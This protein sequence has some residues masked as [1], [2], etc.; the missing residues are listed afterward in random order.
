MKRLLIMLLLLSSSFAVPTF[1]Y[2]RLNLER[3]WVIENGEGSTVDFTGSLV[4][5]NSNQR[6]ISISVAHPA[7]YSVDEDGEVK[8]KYKG[9]VNSSSFEIKASA[10]VNVDYDTAITTDVPLP[11]ANLS[12]TNLTA[13]DEGIGTEA[14]L[15]AEQDSSLKTMRNTVNWINEN[16]EYDLAYWGQSSP[17]TQVFAERKG[18]CVEYS[19]LLISMLRSAGIE[20]RYVSGYVHTSSWQPHAWVEAYLPG[21]G[22]V[23]LDPTFSQAGILDSSHIAMSYGSD[24]SDPFDL[25]LSADQDISIQASNSVTEEFSGE[26][27]KGV[28]LS[29][30]YDNKTYVIDVFTENT[31]S[32]YVLG[33]YEFKVPDGYGSSSSS[34]VLLSPKEQVHKYYGLNH[35]LFNDGYS[36]NVPA[37]ASFNDAK[38][39]A[40]IA[41]TGDYDEGNG[42]KTAESCPIA[43]LL[44]SLLFARVL[45]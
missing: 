20:T 13:P 18:V 41:I 21:Y 35:S 5:N 12:F 16:L 33:S 43:F 9:Q 7:E 1:G 44:L 36:Y 4:V 10:L 25:L 22:W 39:K 26:D 6:V 8:V 23:S 30:D 24:Q 3:T 11:N 17:A 42:Y 31:R 45:H 15:L 27:E 28:L 19:H 2:S 37:E 38:D 32:Q 29:L 40:S 34:I 14:R